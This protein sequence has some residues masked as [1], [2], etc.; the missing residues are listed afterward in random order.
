MAMPYLKVPGAN[1]YY[2]SHGEGKPPLVMVHGFT[3]SHE[4]WRFQ[5]AHFSPSH[6]VLT[7]DLRGHGR[8]SLDDPSSCT[9]KNCAKDVKALLEALD[10]TGVVLV[11]H[12]ISVRV[13]LEVY[14]TTAERVAGLVLLEGSRIAAGDPQAGAQIARNLITEHG[15]ESFI[16]KGFEAMF[17]PG[18]DPALVKSMIDRALVCPQEVGIALWVDHGAWDAQY[19]DEALSRVKVPLLVLQS[20]EFVGTHV[21]IPLQP[22]EISPWMQL[23]KRQAPQAQ[24][25]TVLG[26]GH[27]CMLQASEAVNQALARFLSTMMA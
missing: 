26:V 11:G 8:S 24:L 17:F 15:Y 16:R 5:V 14:L 2:E 20:T 12:S 25:E 10:L 27:F 18:S 22:G 13:V 9:I 23:V 4:D 6:R 3:C 21:R 1:I 19:M 7:P